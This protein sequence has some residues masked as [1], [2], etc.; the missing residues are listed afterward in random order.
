M[1]WLRD[2]IASDLSLIYMI[3]NNCIDDF[4]IMFGCDSV[5]YMLLELV[6]VCYVLD[7]L[8]RITCV[9]LNTIC[10]L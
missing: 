9:G 3:S 7:G 1:F 2:L 10:Y 5:D 8:L 4:C 6:Y